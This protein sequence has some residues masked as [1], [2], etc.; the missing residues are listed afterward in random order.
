M[1]SVVAFVVA[2]D[3]TWAPATEGSKMARAMP[4]VHMDRM[5]RIK[6]RGKILEVLLDDGGEREYLQKLVYFPRFSPLPGPPPMGEGEKGVVFWIP[7]EG[8]DGNAGPLCFPSVSDSVLSAHL[9]PIFYA[10]ANG[11]L[12]VCCGCQAQIFFIG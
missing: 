8:A 4:A 6:I 7:H 10:L 12:S 1:L 11:A 9:Y 3:V 2:E 5:K